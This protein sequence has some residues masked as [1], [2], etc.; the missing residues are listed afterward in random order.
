MALYL[1]TSALVKLVVA[2]PESPA[3]AA[4]LSARN[5]VLVS[6][7]LTRTELQHAV[8]RVAPNRMNRVRE[9]LATVTTTRLTAAICD[10]AGRLDP[11]GLRSLDALHLA[12]ALDLGDD[13]EGLVG[14]DDRLADGARTLGIPVVAP[15]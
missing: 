6:S 7:D 12:S 1:D 10:T 15:T 14:Y 13:L 11:P 9:V 5:A 3:L 2:E 4:Y 8:R